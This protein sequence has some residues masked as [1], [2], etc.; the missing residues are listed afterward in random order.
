M[1][2][3]PRPSPQAYVNRFKF[4]SITADD[5]LGFFLEYFPEL[6]EKGVD[7]IPGQ[8]GPFLARGPRCRFADQHP[9]GIRAVPCPLQPPCSLVCTFYWRCC[10]W[11]WPSRD[12]ALT[13]AWA[14]A[15]SA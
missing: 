15:C 5:A 6:K 10:Y 14:H 2:S 12:E 1:A 4:Q 7:T 13:W 9:M 11:L 3:R 8:H